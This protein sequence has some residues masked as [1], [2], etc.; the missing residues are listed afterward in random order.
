M[1]M[2]NPIETHQNPS[3]GSADRWKARILAKA[4]CVVLGLLMLGPVCGEAEA[5]DVKVIVNASSSLDTV[6]KKDVTRI[7]FRR[8]SRW[9]NGERA[10]PIDQNAKS[11]VRKDFCEQVLGKTT[12]EVDSFWNSQVFAGKATP[13]PTAS[14]DREVLEFVRSNPGGVGYVSAGFDTTGVKVLKV[15]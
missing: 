6:T 11:E 14:S 12:K 5:A 4:A 7:F 2:R 15:E 13:P 9:P 10:K 1:M 3:D 8:K